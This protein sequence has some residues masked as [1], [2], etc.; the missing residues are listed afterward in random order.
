MTADPTAPILTEEDVAKAKDFASLGAP[1]FAAQRIVG[2]ALDG[3]P[4]NVLQPIVK[5]FTDAA[6]EAIQEAVEASIWSDAEHNLQG[7]F[8]SGIDEVI[9][10]LI[11]G[12]PWAL[13]RYG[14][15][16][17]RYTSRAEDIRKA[18]AA[19]IPREIMDARIA[20]LEAE[21]AKLK[22]TIQWL[23]R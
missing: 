13:E 22:E 10:A 15:C 8:W 1:Y 19:H 2:A 4:D 20:D 7:K 3:L 14:L 21:V 6:Y 17:E 18:I 23:R 16:A 11:T 12:Q 5:K 9:D